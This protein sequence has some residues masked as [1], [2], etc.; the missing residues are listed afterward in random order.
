MKEYL[1]LIVFTI[2]ISDVSLC[3]KKHEPE[4][5]VKC[6]PKCEEEFF[7]LE[8]HMDKAIYINP[9]LEIVATKSIENNSSEMAE[10]IIEYTQTLSRTHKFENTVGVST[11]FTAEVG[12]PKV[13]SFGTKF[14]TTKMFTTGD[15]QTK[16]ET[17]KHTA[18]CRAP[19]MTFTKCEVIKK[20]K[21]GKIPYTI[22][23]KTR[24][25]N[26]CHKTSTGIKKLVSRCLPGKIKFTTGVYD[27]ET[28]Y[29]YHLTTH[30]KKFKKRY[31]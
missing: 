15:S 14:D 30:S 21:S 1:L 20:K 23:S 2:C 27:F 5:G 22:K 12:I 24:M 31:F 7:N 8:Y 25:Y 28:I 16:T 11:G 19:P 10:T 3:G 9:I 17:T 26:V 18:K 13:A 6:Y 4:Y 29:D